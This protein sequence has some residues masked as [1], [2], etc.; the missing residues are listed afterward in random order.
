M[1]TYA[2]QSDCFSSWEQEALS[3]HRATARVKAAQESVLRKILMENSATEYGKRFGFAET[4]SSYEYRER[5]PMVDY[6]AIES[7]VERIAGG[8]HDILFR[9]RP[10]CLQPTAGTTSGSKMIP[11]TVALRKEFQRGVAAWHCDMWS[12]MPGMR[13]GKAY[14][15]VSPVLGEGRMTTGGIPVG[16]LDDTEY[17]TPAMASALKKTFAVPNSV[18]LVREGELFR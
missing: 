14:W 11:F 12:Q 13:Q 17:L 3:F 7:Y 18:G 8:E 1:K 9:G 4:T 10:L 2:T 15:S 6:A 5:V 16:F